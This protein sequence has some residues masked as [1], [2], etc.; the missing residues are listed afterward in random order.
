MH[1]MRKFAI[2]LALALCLAIGLPLAAQSPE[3]IARRLQDYRKKEVMLP[4]RDGTRL[5]TAVYEPVSAPTPGPLLIMRTPYACEPYGQGFTPLLRTSLA[6]YVEC[7]YTLV[8]QNVRGRHRS[9]GT[10][11]QIRPL[12]N[13][14]STCLTDEATDTYDTIEWLLKHTRNNGNAGLWGVSYDG[15]YAMMGALCGHPALKAVSPQAP[16]YDWFVGDDL[17]QNG[18]LSLLPALGFLPW[19]EGKHE[20]KGVLKEIVKNDAYA[21]LL[22]TGTFQDIDRAVA[23]TGNTQWNML[24]KHPD[25]DCYWQQRNLGQAC[26]DVQPAVLVTGG[27]FDCEDGYGTWQLY[28]AI[29]SQ[30]PSTELYLAIGPWW[31]GAWRQNDF[32]NIGPVY[33]GENTSGYFLREIEFPFFRRYLEGKGEGPAHR[34]NVFHTG[35]NR[36][37]HG[38]EWPLTPTRETALYLHRDGKI[39]TVPPQEPEAFSEYTSDMEHPVPYTDY[40]TQARAK[41]YMAGDQRFAARRA[42][43]LTFVSDVL[44][45]P[46]TLSGTVSAELKVAIGSTDADFVVKLIDVFP[47]RLDRTRDSLALRPGTDYPM[48]SYQMLVR[49]E[50]FRGR[51]RESFSQPRPFCPDS[52]TA[53]SFAMTDVAHTFLPGHRLMVQIQSTWYPIIDRNPQRFINP[54]ACTEKEMVMKQRVR[55]YHSPN[56]ASRI[57]V[58]STD[59]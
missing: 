1:D 45:E 12:R 57:V 37:R 15:F 11:E 44:T 40:P 39:D 20:G 4:M 25:Y 24:K 31:H 41:E 32:K 17:H 23:D 19:L 33:F 59:E 8:F 48:E 50:A 10:F 28:K 38:T 34:V 51:Y 52:V 26:Q 42:D 5:Y 2:T 9:E 53:V 46:F 18:A 43:V 47:A 27:L 35:E 6:A 16:V 22:S 49:G 29:R 58:E 13:P 3:H 14:D 55:I 7:G 36:W 54:Y 30:S 21:D 56:A